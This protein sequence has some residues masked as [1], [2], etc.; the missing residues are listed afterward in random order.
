MALEEAEGWAVAVTELEVAEGWEVAVMVM[1]EAAV[2]AEVEAFQ[3]AHLEYKEDRQAVAERARVM[4]ADPLGLAAW[5]VAM[6]AVVVAVVYQVMAVTAV[7]V[8]EAAAMAAASLV[9][10][11]GG[12]AV[13]AV[14]GAATAVAK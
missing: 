11:E 4:A 3:V 8:W 2:R 14:E 6:A 5:A 1:V 7:V 10:A 9:M 12:L 13:A